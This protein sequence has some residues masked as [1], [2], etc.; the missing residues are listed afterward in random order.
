MTTNKTLQ[1]IGL[2]PRELIDEMVSK[3]TANLSALL[4]EKINSPKP[5]EILTRK[6][7]AE[8]LQKDYSTLHRWKEQGILQPTYIEGSVYYYKK[9]IEAIL[10][11]NK[12][13]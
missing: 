11:R 3:V 7:V 4:N 12:G 2:E 13:L 6:E 1:L 5:I 9:D 8:L 10:E